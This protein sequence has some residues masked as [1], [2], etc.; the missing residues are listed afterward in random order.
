MT[1]K[2][3]S[4]F[5]YGHTVDEN[6]LNL[7]FSEGGG[8]IVAELNVGDYS[9]EKFVVEVAR[10]LNAVSNKYYVVTVNRTTR[11]ITISGD[12]NFEL[13][14][15]SSGLAIVS[16]FPLLGFDQATDKTG[17]NTYQGVNASGKEYKTQFKLQNYKPFDNEQRA[18]AASIN[19]S[20]TGRVEIISY[21]N[22]KTMTL[23]FTL[24]N[25]FERSKNPSIREN[26][27]GVADL[28]DL[29][30]YLIGK[31]EVEF[32]ENEND[33]NSF[34]TCILDEANNG[35]NGTGFVI[36]ELYTQGLAGFYELKGLKFRKIE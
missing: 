25:D 34:D 16:I 9:L 22:V 13:L 35:Q 15:N 36:N 2:T 12:S 27:T 8:E 30:E 10:A 31:G 17:A 11:Q 33:V 6:N 1:V 26:L 14:A 32:M 20:A 23:D 24:V 4:K 7:P 5:Y 29:M 3:H 21:G 28:R 19:E 18:S